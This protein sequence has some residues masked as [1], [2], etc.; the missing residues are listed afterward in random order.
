MDAGYSP[1]AVALAGTSEDDFAARVFKWDGHSWQTVT[2]EGNPIGWIPN[3]KDTD[4]L[5]APSTKPELCV[6]QS[7]ARKCW[8][9]SRTRLTGCFG[10]RASMTARVLPSLGHVCSPFGS[11]AAPFAETQ[12]TSS[13]TST[14]HANRHTGMLE[15]RTSQRTCMLMRPTSGWQSRRIGSSAS[16]S[17]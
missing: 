9:A 3:R 5:R 13:R 4:T 7:P 11:R 8:L 6:P 15:S 12:T 16:L 10:N 14:A 1:L 17:A 2:Y